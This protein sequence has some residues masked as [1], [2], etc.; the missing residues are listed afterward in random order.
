MT[1]LA[2]PDFIDPSHAD[3]EL[4]AVELATRIR[5]GDLP[6]A[7][8]SRALA[9][10]DACHFVAPARSGRRR[11]DQYGHLILTSGWLK[12]YGTLDVSVAWS[13]VSSV[14][15]A[16]RDLVVSLENSRRLLRFSCHSVT[17]AACG[18]V[19]AEHL[20]GGARVYPLDVESA[21][22]ASV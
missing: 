14:R 7:K 15:R 18:G 8:A 11:S 1:P 12:F 3:A 9:P 10:G 20:A 22:H 17:E 21:Y 4:D 2:A 16:G 13:E 6:T 19:I 5:L